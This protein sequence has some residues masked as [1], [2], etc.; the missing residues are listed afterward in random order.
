VGSHPRHRHAVAYCCEVLSFRQARA[1]ICCL[2][3]QYQRFSLCL[4]C[5]VNRKKILSGKTKI[6]ICGKLMWNTYQSREVKCYAG[7]SRPFNV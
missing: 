7:C 4:T 2:L 3:L 6:L 5:V 1:Q